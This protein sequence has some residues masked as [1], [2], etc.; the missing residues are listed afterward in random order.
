[1]FATITSF[2]FISVNTANFYYKITDKLTAKYQRIYI[3][4]TIKIYLK[5]L[6]ME[7]ICR[8][9]INFLLC[10]RVFIHL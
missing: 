1:M 3:L 10:K 6:H 9:Y 2:F 7:L 4:Y 8:S 5:I